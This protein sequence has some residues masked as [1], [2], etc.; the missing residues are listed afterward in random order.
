M[1]RETTRAQA[2]Q[3]LALAALWLLAGS[4]PLG[5]QSAAEVIRQV[6]FKQR[7][8]QPLPLELRFRDETGRA[9]A[10]GDYFGRRPVVLALVYYECPMLCNYV[11]NGLVKALRPLSFEP[12]R[13]FDVVFVSFA[14]EE[15]PA[16][17][18]AK[19][20]SVLKEYDRARTAAG[21]HFLTGEP[22]AIRPLTEAVGFHYL[23]DEKSRQYAHA[24]GVIVVTPDGKLFRYFYGIEYAPRDLRLA[25]VEAS[26]NKLGTP[27]DQ[28]LLYCFHYDPETGKY[29]VLITRV[30]RLAGS[31]TALALAVFLVVMFRRERRLSAAAGR[32]ADP[33]GTVK[34]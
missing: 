20:E 30:I 29:G 10:L 22:D 24:S 9:V 33:R 31:G 21:W 18:A 14:P 8:N 3:A 27:V 26:A 32:G 1:T 7:I 13:E 19:K 15:T 17:A 25:L 28:V 23:Y 5:A 6:A 16:L 11:E 12:G 34:A 2:V 4:A